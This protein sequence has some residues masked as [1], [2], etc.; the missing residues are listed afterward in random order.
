[1]QEQKKPAVQVQEKSQNEEKAEVQEAEAQPEKK[2]RERKK[3]N[4]APIINWLGLGVSVAVFCLFVFLL[5][6]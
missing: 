4:F 3:I 5:C 6:K 2:K 1:M